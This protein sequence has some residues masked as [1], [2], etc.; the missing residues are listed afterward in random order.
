[1]KENYLQPWSYS[2]A[3]FSNFVIEDI[4]RFLRCKDLKNSN[5]LLEAKGQEC[6]HAFPDSFGFVCEL[7]FV[8]PV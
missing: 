5:V 8:R 7:R 6:I 1:M 3:F 2:F 4:Q